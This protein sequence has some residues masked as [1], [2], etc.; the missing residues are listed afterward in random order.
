MAL[1]Q[2]QDYA[3][4]G[5]VYAADIDISKFFDSV[6]HSKLMQILADTIKD[7]ALLSLI[8]KYLNSGAMQHG[9]FYDTEEGVQQ[10]GLCRARHKPPYVEII[11]MPT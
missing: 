3:D 1:Q 9:M 8:H 10:G 6:S 2:V 5:Y 11:V 4:E 7:G